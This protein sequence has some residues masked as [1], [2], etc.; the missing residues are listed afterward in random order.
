V[1][2]SQ[3][4]ARLA[5]E[6]SARVL[7]AV[8]YAL[9]LGWLAW[10]GGENDGGATDY[11][12]AIKVAVILVWLGGSVFAGWYIGAVALTVPVVAVI[13]AASIGEAL[14]Q[15]DNEV[16]VI[17]WIIQ[18]VVSGAFIVVGLWLRERRRRRVGAH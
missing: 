14:H 10:T 7:T 2:S 15:F 1:I 4:R 16:R 6:M 11:P 8:A 18:P 5:R 9:F 3:P 12:G 17:N 13:T